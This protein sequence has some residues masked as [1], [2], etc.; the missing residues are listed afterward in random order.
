MKSLSQVSAR[1]ALVASLAALM[2]AACGLPPD[3]AEDTTASNA[4]ALKSRSHSSPPPPSSSVPSLGS[5]S[6]FAVL[7]AST[8]TCASGSAITG[9]VGV[10]PGTAI[11][12]FNPDCTI[13]GA[14][15]AGDGVAA[16]AHNDLLTAYNGLAGVACLHNLTNQDLGGKTLAPGVYCFDS[17]VGLTG[18]LTL[19]GGGDP[20]AVWIFQIAST[21]TAASNSA[22]VMAGSGKPCNVF[23]QVGSSA[24]IGTN[25]AFQ[26]N[27]VAFASVTLVSGTS[28][29]GRALALNAAVTLDHNNITLGNCSPSSV[30]ACASEDSASGSGYLRA[31]S[32]AP[33]KTFTVQGGLKHGAFFGQLDFEDFGAAGPTVH[34]QSV[35]GYSALDAKT[36][37]IQGAAKVNGI[38]GFTYQVDVSDKGGAG[39]L[40]TFS[41]QLSNGYSASGVLANGN[42]SLKCSR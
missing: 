16:Q 14:I 27:L 35:T 30:S 22:V 24:T 9:D 13:S 26:G 19:D 42:I 41:V 20:N 3:A 25:S 11:T 1:T 21:L 5:A 29:V 15:H 36:R 39:G 4:D 7:A 33:K 17:S 31:S 8:V 6:Q 23:W 10:S 34:S 40:D 2:F 38:S 37:R 32:S 12:G 18:Q 28:L